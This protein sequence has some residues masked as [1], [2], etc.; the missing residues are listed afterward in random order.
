MVQC[1]IEPDNF[2]IDPETRQVTII[3]FSCVCVLPS[4]FVGFTMYKDRSF[5]KGVNKYLKWKWSDNIIGLRAATEIYCFSASSTL[6]KPHLLVCYYSFE[7]ITVILQAL[8]R[9]AFQCKKRNAHHCQCPREDI[10]ESRLVPVNLCPTSC[11]KIYRACIYSSLFLLRVFLYC[12]SD[13]QYYLSN[14]NTFT[15]IELVL[16]PCTGMQQPAGCLYT[17]LTMCVCDHW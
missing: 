10:L 13:T 2:L 1:D 7:L 11:N 8:T 6:G 17:F 9:M 4:S 3:D 12:L 15:R 16:F 5:I 14:N